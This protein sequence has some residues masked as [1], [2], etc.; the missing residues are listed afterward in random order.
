MKRRDREID[1]AKG[2]CI[3]CMILVHATYGFGDYSKINTYT[4]VFFLVFFFFS[5]GFYYRK[6]MDNI[7]YIA[8]RLER[9]EIPYVCVCLILFLKMYSHGF[10][11]VGVLINS[12]FYA[13]PSGF[14]APYMIAG[15]S[16]IGIGP[17]W[18]L[19]CLFVTCLFY[20]PV[21]RLEMKS[22]TIVVIVLAVIAKISQTN[23]L[24]PFN[25]QDAL[26]GMMFFHAG[27]AMYPYIKRATDWLREHT[28]AALGVCIAALF[29]YVTEIRHLPYQ[30]FN[31]GGNIYNFQSLPG[32]FTGF[33]L[34]LLL[35]VLF[36]K[37]PLFSDLL[38]F[39]GANSMVVLVLHSI[40]ITTF[41]NWGAMSWFNIILTLIYYIL[42]TFI[43][44]EGKSRIKAMLIHEK[45]LHGD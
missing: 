24:L 3:I 27:Q 13:L 45:E 20:L 31:L 23:I 43:Y 30:W 34:V 6:P 44:V 32:S 38:G 8:Q 33:A 29:L 42:I 37:T 2:I 39:V 35:S 28:P 41:R 17:I 15:T 26:I 40:D 22:R 11:N 4:G 9:L 7:N 36:I 5:A 12:F 14:S 16:T 18:F 10:Q 21:S 25:I 1:V 19:N